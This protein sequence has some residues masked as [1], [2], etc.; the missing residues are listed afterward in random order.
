MS[1]EVKQNTSCILQNFNFNF[2]F[3][4]LTVFHL[5]VIL[6]GKI[7][8]IDLVLSRNQPLF[9]QHLRLRIELKNDFIFHTYRIYLLTLLLN[10]LRH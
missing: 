2:N 1:R 9:L 3:I 6:F 7:V 5:V 8:N 10:R 4:K